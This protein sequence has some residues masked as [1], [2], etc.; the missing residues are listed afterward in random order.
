MR[1]ASTDIGIQALAERAYDQIKE[2]F[3]GRWDW[4]ISRKFIIPF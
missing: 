2:S 1:A 4:A 3:P